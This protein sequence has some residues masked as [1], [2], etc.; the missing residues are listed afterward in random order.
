MKEFASE[1]RKE[2]RVKIFS[3]CRSLLHLARRTTIYLT[4]RGLILLL[5]LL[6]LLKGPVFAEADIVAAVLAFSLLLVLLAAALATLVCGHLIRRGSAVAIVPSFQLQAGQNRIESKDLTVFTIRV[7][8][9]SIPPLFQMTLKLRFAHGNLLLPTHLLKGRPRGDRLITQPL[10]FPHR[11]VWEVSEAELTFGDQLGL[12]SLRWTIKSDLISQPFEVFPPRLSSTRLPVLCSCFR[13]G[14]DVIDT[15]ERQGEP[16]DLK[17]YHPSDGMRKIAWKLFAR[18]GV[19]MS[20]HPEPAASPEGQVA[21]FCL[22]APEE[23]QV[24]SS[25]AAYMRELESRDLRILFACQGMEDAAVLSAEEAEKAMVESAWRASGLQGAALNRA[26]SKFLDRVREELRGGHLERVLIFTAADRLENPRGT[27]I[28]TDLGDLLENRGIKPAFFLI[29]EP[30]SKSGAAARSSAGN[31]LL[32]RWFFISTGE[33]SSPRKTSHS[34][35]FL[36]TSVRKHWAVVA[37]QE[38]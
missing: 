38:L 29:G 7:E 20:R 1:N 34:P 8:G 27:A 30:R 35:D 23:D 22:A 13:P 25:A 5:F 21:I 6:Y 10:R 33:V 4:A 11:G 9:C 15:K 26:L 2:M 24:C 12:T 3:A 19:L 36:N 16:F 31:G 17:R 18:S 32:Q 28:L 37:E 14:E